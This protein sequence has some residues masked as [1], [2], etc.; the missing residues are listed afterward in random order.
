[1][2]H[3]SELTDTTDVKIPRMRSADTKYSGTKRKWSF[4]PVKKAQ[5]R[6]SFKWEAMLLLSSLQSTFSENQSSSVQLQHRVSKP[7]DKSGEQRGPHKL[8]KSFSARFIIRKI[9]WKCGEWTE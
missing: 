8:F 3:P 4:G 2:Q 7:T 5:V 6:E 9:C 1:M